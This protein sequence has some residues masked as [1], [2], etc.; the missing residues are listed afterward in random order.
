MD[1]TASLFLLGPESEFV[2]KF[3]HGL[4]AAELAARLGELIAD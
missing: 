3:A 1:H 4:P 2:A